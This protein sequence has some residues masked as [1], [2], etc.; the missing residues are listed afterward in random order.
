[1]RNMC[2]LAF[3]V[4]T[5]KKRSC[6]TTATRIP[7]PV[8]AFSFHLYTVLNF[9]TVLEKPHLDLFSNYRLYI[10]ILVLLFYLFRLTLKSQ[11]TE[12]LVLMPTEEKV[13]PCHLPHLTSRHQ[14][15]LGVSLS[16]RIFA[17]VSG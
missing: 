1:M 16:T 17:K 11:S 8:P 12:I 5:M 10:K 4:V 3:A 9:S 15:V 14:Y 6:Q 13:D 2:V 7:A